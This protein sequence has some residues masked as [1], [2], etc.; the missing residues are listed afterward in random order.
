[1]AG[2][3]PARTWDVITD[4]QG[5]ATAGAGDLPGNGRGAHGL[6]LGTVVVREVRPPAG[7][8]LPDPPTLVRAVEPSPDEPNAAAYRVPTVAEQVVRGAVALL[9][10]GAGTSGDGAADNAGG[11]GANG[12]SADAA[13]A[14]PQIPLAGVAFDIVHLSTGEVAEMCIRDRL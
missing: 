7:Y 12:A 9:K 13:G 3:R 4:E 14:T 8:L 2:A 5:R 6:P 10:L 1:M 11:G